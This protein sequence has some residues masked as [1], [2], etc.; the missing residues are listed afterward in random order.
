MEG[1]YNPYITIPLTTWLIAQVI[2]F[3]RRAWQ[4]EVDF[5]L[6]Y[7][8]GGMP[9]AH[10]AVVV[11]LAVTTLILLGPQ[12]P[13][14]GLAVVVATIV[15]YDSF[16]VRRA[17]GDQAVAINNLIEELSRT[18]RHHTYEAVQLR[19]IT[20]HKPSEVTAGALLGT[21]VSLTMT[22]PVWS[23]QA[24]FLLAGPAATERVIYLTVFAVLVAGAIVG[25]FATTLG[26]RRTLHT[27][28]LLRSV[29]L[30][31]LHVPGWVGLVVVLMEYESIPVGQWRVWPL[32]LLTL[33]L[34]VHIVLAFKWY[35]HIPQRLREDARA[36]RQAR[37]SRHRKRRR[38]KRS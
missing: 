6:L 34:A 37:R 23:G 20:G 16:G 15:M 21:A 8:S 26:G 4:Q 13:L 32:L 11:S 9:S 22:Y 28:Q 35:R 24:A 3:G 17:S 14:F 36:R 19:E 25:R 5:K 1:L 18:Q 29:L 12:S 31:S 38:K 30:W 7:S 2:K 10:S 27:S 33:L